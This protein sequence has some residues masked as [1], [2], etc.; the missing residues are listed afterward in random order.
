MDTHG[1]GQAQS[2]N[3]RGLLFNNDKASVLFHVIT[4][5]CI[6]NLEQFSK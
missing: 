6:R 4:P 3:Y 5:L 2:Q 1:H